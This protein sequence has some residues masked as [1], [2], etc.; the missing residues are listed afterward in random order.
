MSAID[1]SLDRLTFLTDRARDALRK[2]LRELA[3]FF[4]ILL[5]LL[6]SVA[7]ATWSVQDP[8]LSH[9]T[10]SAIRN[11]LGFGG[12]IVSDLLMQL[13]GVAS[14]ALVLPVGIWG[15]RL[16]S[17]R[18]LARERIRLSVWIAGVAFVAAFAS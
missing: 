5:A 7:L 12:A 17:H 6:L 10:N 18:P 15:W 8:S 13:L 3:G 14:L 1:R 11:R 2:R 16:A 4:L 9:A